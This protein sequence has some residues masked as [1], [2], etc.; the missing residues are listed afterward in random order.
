LIAAKEVDIRSVGLVPMLFFGSLGERTSK[1]ID[2]SDVLGA[3]FVINDECVTLVLG[4][5]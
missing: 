1:V 5:T 4:A 3:C 2:R